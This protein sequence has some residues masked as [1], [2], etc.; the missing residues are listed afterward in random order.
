MRFG[1]VFAAIALSLPA[2]AAAQQ[3]PNWRAASSGNA[4]AAFIDT[5]S[6]VRSG[7]KVRIVR[8]VRS[9][10]PMA[11]DDGTRFDSLGSL[12]EFDC[13]ANTLRTIEVWVRLGSRELVR[14]PGDNQIDAVRPGTT[15]ATDL[16]AA[17]FDEWP[18]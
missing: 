15:A 14:G 4:Q 9:R 3:A 18:G 13:R 17:C 11:F 2:P 12:I 1:F 7:D 5:N 8:E 6:I 10:E 16:R